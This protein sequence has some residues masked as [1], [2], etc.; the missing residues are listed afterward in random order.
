MLTFDDYLFELYRSGQISFE[1]GYR[2][3]DSGNEF[4]LKVKLDNPA[5]TERG[6][7]AGT[8]SEDGGE[9]AAAAP[10]TKVAPPPEEVIDF[11]IL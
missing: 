1:D 4:R 9:G 2:N 6:A 7:A 3:A 11:K 5:N 10:V 8:E